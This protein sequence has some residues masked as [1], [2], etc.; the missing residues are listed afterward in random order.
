MC[1]I[2]CKKNVLERIYDKFSFE[3]SNNNSYWF[4]CVVPVCLL[5]IYIVICSSPFSNILWYTYGFRSVS[6]IPPTIIS[7]SIYNAG[8]MFYDLRLCCSAMSLR[9]TYL[10]YFTLWCLCLTQYLQ[11]SYYPAFQEEP[12]FSCFFVLWRLRRGRVL[13]WSSLVFDTTFF[14]LL[15][16]LH[17]VSCFAHVIFL[18]HTCFCRTMQT[19]AVVFGGGNHESE[20]SETPLMVGN[21]KNDHSTVS[22][23]NCP[24][25]ITQ[26][27][28]R[29]RLVC[30]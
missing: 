21:G 29:E 15:F 6:M 13:G 1:Y 10:Q 25:F 26:E 22:S 9:M 11:L 17:V 12:F 14:L 20:M 18:M 7:Q 28:C 8:E 5:K 19:A 4:L 3:G 24:P 2:E 27:L 23:Q 30:V 16:F